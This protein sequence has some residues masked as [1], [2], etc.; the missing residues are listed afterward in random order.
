MGEGGRARTREA[1]A[2]EL[3]IMRKSSPVARFRLLRDWE[4]SGGR[5]PGRQLHLQS[6]PR[7]AP[8]SGPIRPAYGRPH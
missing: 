4:K 3:S 7:P 2:N 1:K 5:A 8:S 6:H